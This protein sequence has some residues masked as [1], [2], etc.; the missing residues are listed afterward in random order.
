MKK[1]RPSKRAKYG[2]IL[3]DE[4]PV[5]HI[6]RGRA[7]HS[8]HTTTQLSF[9]LL[10]DFNECYTAGIGILEQYEGDLTNPETEEVQAD[11]TAARRA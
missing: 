8:S 7:L 10:D 5:F 11:D 2:V 3:E 9:P 6:E 4:E 1:G